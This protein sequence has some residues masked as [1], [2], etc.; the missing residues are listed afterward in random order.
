MGQGVG[1][2]YTCCGS[3]LRADPGCDMRPHL[4]LCADSF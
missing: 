1:G 3:S 4:E 2:R